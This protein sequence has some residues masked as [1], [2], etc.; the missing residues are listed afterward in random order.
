MPFVNPRLTSPYDGSYLNYEDMANLI[1]QDGGEFFPITYKGNLRG[2]LE[3]HECA[4][5]NQLKPITIVALKVKHSNNHIGEVLCLI[6]N[7][8]GYN[9]ICNLLA[10]HNEGVHIDLTKKLA[11]EWKQDLSGVWLITGGENSAIYQTL[12]ARYELDTNHPKYNEQHR[13][14][15]HTAVNLLK[16]AN[17]LS[18]TGFALELPCYSSKE[19]FTDFETHLENIY[20]SLSQGVR[21][22]LLEGL[23][24]FPII[25]THN[26]TFA[27]QGDYEFAKR[28]VTEL[29]RSAVVHEKDYFLTQNDVENLTFSGNL[30]ELLNLMPSFTLQHHS[31]IIP[32]KPDSWGESANEKLERL[33]LAGLKRRLLD[34]FQNTQNSTNLRADKMEFAEQMAI[35]TQMEPPLSYAEAVEQTHLYQQYKERLKY[36]LNIL[37]EC[38]FSAYIL[39]VQDLINIA[40]DKNIPLGVGRG[41]SVGSLVCYALNITQVDPIEHGL[42]FERFINPERVGFPDI[43]IDV[44]TKNREAF[45]DAIQQVYGK[46][47]VAQVGV[48]STYQIGQASNVVNSIYGSSNK[49][50]DNEVFNPLKELQRQIRLSKDINPIPAEVDKILSDDERKNTWLMSTLRQPEKEAKGVLEMYRTHEELREYSYLANS[51]VGRVASLS[52][53]PAAIVISPSSISQQY[54]TR[55]SNA[56]SVLLIDMGHKEVEQL[57]GVKTDILSL[58]AVDIIQDCIHLSA[59]LDSSERPLIE[60]LDLNDS[61]I[62]ERVFQRGDTKNIF[63]FSS[64]EMM[65]VLRNFKPQNFSDLTMIMALYRPGAKEYISNAIAVRNGKQ[66]TY[67]SDEI[68]F[69]LSKEIQGLL[70]ETYGLLVYQEQIMNLCELYSG[71][72]KAMADEMRRAIS[73]KQSHLVMQMKEDFV[74][75]AVNLHKKAYPLADE[76]DLE[77]KR[78]DAEIIFAQIEKFAGYGFNKS[79]AVAYSKMAIQMAFF[80]TYYPEVFGAVMMQHHLQNNKSELIHDYQWAVQNGVEIMPTDYRLS[81]SAYHVVQEDGEI[82]IVEPLFQEYEEVIESLFPNL[83]EQNSNEITQETLLKAIQNTKHLTAKKLQDCLASGA[84]QSLIPDTENLLNIYSQIPNL[85]NNNQKLL[86]SWDGF[87]CAVKIKE[88]YQSNKLDLKGLQEKIDSHKILSNWLSDAVSV[89]QA[90]DQL[91]KYV[92]VYVPQT[93]QTLGL[94]DVFHDF[95]QDSLLLKQMIAPDCYHF[96]QQDNFEKF[97]TNKDKKGVYLG[98]VAAI[99]PNTFDTQITI[100]VNDGKEFVTAHH[101]DKNTEWFLGQSVAF[102]GTHY[103]HSAFIPNKK[104]IETEDDIAQIPSGFSVESVTPIQQ[105]INNRFGGIHIQTNTETEMQ[106]KEAVYEKNGLDVLYINQHPVQTTLNSEK[107]DLL[108]NSEI[109]LKVLISVEDLNQGKL[110]TQILLKEATQEISK[111]M[112]NQL[113][114]ISMKC[115]S[116]LPYLNKEPGYHKV[117]AENMISLDHLPVGKYFVP[118]QIELHKTKNN[119]TQATLILPEELGG[120]VVSNVWDNTTIGIEQMSLDL[121]K[122]HLF[123]LNRIYSAKYKVNNAIVGVVNTVDLDLSNNMVLSEVS[124]PLLHEPFKPENYKQAF[125]RLVHPYKNNLNQLNMR[126]LS[127]QATGYKEDKDIAFMV[128]SKEN[129]KGGNWYTIND[130]TAALRVNVPTWLCKKMDEC[131]EKEQP[132]LGKLTLEWK[133]NR[134]FHNLQHIV[135][136]Q[137]AQGVTAERLEVITQ[138]QGDNSELIQCLEAI[139]LQN[140]SQINPDANHPIIQPVNLLLKKPTGEIIQTYS[141][142]PHSHFIRYL[143]NANLPYCEKVNVYA[144]QVL[145]SDLYQRNEKLEKLGAKVCLDHKNIPTPTTIKQNPTPQVRKPNTTQTIEVAV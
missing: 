108:R 5:K 55:H 88:P 63:Q 46:D 69:P 77:L 132:V 92:Q 101:A 83:N 144:K 45:I 15:S 125:E 52:V 37:N 119:T 115:L 34:L 80:Q 110:G 8:H 120:G 137:N 43:D 106:W 87:R 4:A 27:K 133:N 12:K 60:D 122:P 7:Q 128:T 40:H 58:G 25:R 66:I 70:N 124:L 79:H 18:E 103:I 20:T 91:T 81:K 99:E 39:M 9:Q 54:P 33:A 113:D 44:G 96:L 71:M 49:T 68:R 30:N 112:S 75:G 21:S 74:N 117:N 76:H 139:V 51:L 95:K 3:H 98:V 73:K 22:G 26:T 10:N 64:N 134:V 56:D 118:A 89:K 16:E 2:I 116:Q 50:N 35:K 138:E 126:M 41:S 105:M 97:K 19:D 47:H 36:E 24:H 62:Y 61:N 78:Q 23:P 17:Q 38:G 135:P 57:G 102:S 53:H 136:L 142:T 48:V 84:F 143:K 130:G 131:L 127:I 28:I 104:D 85:I 109:D 123:L 11:S 59:Q 121:N 100:A 82:K 32:F 72:S 93:N 107:L 13:E 67:L 114:E 31:P 90:L 111:E 145:S 6:K 129:N 42:L 65:M 140:E 14:L 141:V 1:K 94:Y 86:G 29:Q